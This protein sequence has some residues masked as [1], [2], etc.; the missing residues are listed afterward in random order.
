MFGFYTNQ[1]REED[2]FTLIRLDDHFQVCYYHEYCWTGQVKFL[3]SQRKR[4]TKRNSEYLVYR[5]N[6][7]VW[8]TVACNID[9]DTVCEHGFQMCH[10]R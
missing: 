9:I 4:N 3:F 8:Q 2:S 10:I 7:S 1:I 5:V 6:S